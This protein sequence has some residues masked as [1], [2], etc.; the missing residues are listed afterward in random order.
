M[1]QNKNI[2]LRNDEVRDILKKMPHWTIRWG[3][4]I[5]LVAVALLL[6]F[7][8]LYRYPDLINSEV[9]ISATNPPAAMKARSTGKITGI[10]VG[11]GQKTVP[12]EILA[13]IENPAL[14]TD[15]QQLE[16]YLKSMKDFFLNFNI[17]DFQEPPVDLELGYVQ[18]SFTDLAKLVS[19][20][21][22]FIQQKYYGERLTALDGQIEMQQQLSERLEEQKQL[23][24]QRLQLAT[25]SFERDSV[26]FNKRTIPELEY[27]QSKESWLSSKM[28]FEN[29]RS[30]WVSVRS[31]IYELKQQKAQLQLD[32]DNQLKTYKTAIAQAY[33]LLQSA[34]NDWY[35]LYVLKSPIEGTVS[36][37]KVWALNQNVTQG[38]T[39]MTIVPDDPLGISG[40]AY[41]P[42]IGAGKVKPGQ[43]VNIKL[44]NYP[45]MEY[46]MLI[47]K[48]K[49]KAPVPVDNYYAIEIELPD[50]LV[51]N[52][53]NT[54]E[55]QQELLGVAEIITNDRRL[56]ERIVYPI[57]AIVEKNRR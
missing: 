50:S 1:E 44:A 46:G 31:G 27:E 7:S 47:G 10:Y 6:L 9:V 32:Y 25:K 5:I 40:K 11:D 38:E 45:Y 22:F 13:V 29:I 20:Y 37:S 8:Y 3:I 18:S 42:V 24:E 53:G 14:L 23:Q 2:E 28:A 4:T 12:G 55:M 49:R 41:V 26:L 39:V 30:Q 48:V 57:K 17:E 56:I 54:L 35:L 43:R 51:T 33:T 16:E 15:I 34:I 21:R 19:D 52:Y 36:F